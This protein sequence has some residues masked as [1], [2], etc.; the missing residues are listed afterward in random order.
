MLGAIIGDIAGSRYEFN[1]TFDYNFEMFGKGCSY[2]DD[3]ICTMAVADAILKDKAKPDYAGSLVD[4][5]SRYPHPMG[6]YGGRFALWI[7][8]ERHEPYGSFG[9]GSAMRVSPVGGLY[10]NAEEVRAQAAASAN[11]THSH[12]LGR[13]GAI[14]VA[15][16]IFWFRTGKTNEEIIAALDKEFYPG[17][18]TAEYPRGVFDETCQGTVP[19]CLKLLFESKSFEDAIRLG[20][21]WGGDSD[22]IGAI[23]GSMAEAMY[24]IP[25]D[26]AAKALSLLPQEMR[27]ITERVAGS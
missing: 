16:T 19:V 3:S 1:N 4:W 11:V 22:T 2:T 8:S 13:Q 7:R 21:S 17:F 12:P 27:E 9:N 14:A 20:V 18:M 26:L 25:Q 6:S 24:G 15:L 23:I 5:C 10:D